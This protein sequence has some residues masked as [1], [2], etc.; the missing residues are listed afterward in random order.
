VKSLSKSSHLESFA[1]V[2][3]LECRR[4]EFVSPTAF[5]HELDQDPTAIV[6]LEIRVDAGHNDV[7]GP[8]N[9]TPGG[10]AGEEQHVKGLLRIAL[11]DVGRVCLVLGRVANVSE[12]NMQ[13]MCGPNKRG[14]VG[15]V[16]DISARSL[17][18]V[19]DRDANM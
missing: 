16:A 10:P 4:D 11:A 15:N 7:Y 6:E 9:R 14:S 12:V 5:A 1:L 8:V 3:N 13:A 18:G 17:K 2:H 19:N